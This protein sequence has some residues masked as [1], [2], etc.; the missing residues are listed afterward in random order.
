MVG[1]GDESNVA[2][3]ATVLAALAALAVCGHR[4]GCLQVREKPWDW[5]F[6]RMTQKK[7]DSTVTKCETNDRDLK[8]GCVLTCGC[9]PGPNLTHH[10]TLDT[11]HVS[12]SNH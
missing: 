5:T 9:E 1:A 10:H 7:K 6:V 2:S 12:G 8:P 3:E 4:C 11:V